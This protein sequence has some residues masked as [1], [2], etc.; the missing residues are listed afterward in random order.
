MIEDSIV[1]FV[2]AQNKQNSPHYSTDGEVVQMTFG[3][4]DGN[5]SVTNRNIIDATGYHFHS[6]RMTLDVK[7]EPVTKQY[8]LRLKDG[9]AYAEHVVNR[10]DSGIALVKPI[11]EPLN[12][13]D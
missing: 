9:E 1:A 2:N 8:I 10:N 4:V 12:M 11:T 6:G 13:Y 5:P 3:L 7:E